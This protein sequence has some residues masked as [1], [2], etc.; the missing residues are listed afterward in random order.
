MADDGN[1]PGGTSN[2]YTNREPEAT[3]LNKRKSLFIARDYSKGL[4][5]RFDRNYPPQLHGFVCLIIVTCFK[6]FSFEISEEEWSSTIDKVNE[7]FEEAEKVK[8]L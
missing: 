5:V 3:A 1:A 2:S 6:H 4:G 8:L 7:I